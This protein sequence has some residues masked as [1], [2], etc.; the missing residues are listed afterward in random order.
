MK[1]KG[2]T[3][4][5]EPVFDASKTWYL[6]PLSPDDDFF[7]PLYEGKIIEDKRFHL[8]FDD[9]ETR[10]SHIWIADT[11]NICRELSA[12]LIFPVKVC[13]DACIEIEKDNNLFWIVSKVELLKPINYWELLPQSCNEFTGN[14]V[15]HNQKYIPNGLV[16]P[17]ILKGGLMFLNCI[18]PDE[19]EL[20]DEIQEYMT[21]SNSNI[22][23]S[24][25]DKFPSKIDTLTI[26]STLFD[27]AIELPPNL[28]FDEKQVNIFILDNCILPDHFEFPVADSYDF[29]FRDQPI[30][31]RL[32]LP[33]DY[34]G[35]IVF[36]NSILPAWLKLPKKINGEL[37]FYKSKITAALK[38]PENL[39]GKL[40]F[41]K[42]KIPEGF[43]FPE[44]ISGDLL[45]YDCSLPTNI[46][47]PKT[48]E[49]YFVI[50]GGSIPY[51]WKTTLPK[52]VG[53]LIL[54]NLTVSSGTVLPEKINGQ[55]FFDELIAFEEGVIMPSS[56]QSIYANFTDFPSD[57]KLIQSDL[58]KVSFENCILPV[59]F[60][61]P[62][63]RSIELSMGSTKI[64]NDLHLPENFVG[65]LSFCASKIAPR[66][67]LPK[68]F[69]GY[70]DF[71]NLKFPAKLELPVTF[72][73]L[74][75]F[76]LT[77]LP[78]GLKLPDNFT[79][80]LSFSE[81]IMPPNLKFP[82]EF[83]G[84]LEFSEVS[85]PEGFEMPDKL[86]GTLK[87]VDSKINGRLQLH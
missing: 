5:A 17:T 20:P 21:I 37:S 40:E 79:G 45:F 83:H 1:K 63:A 13:N 78:K 16:F 14:I 27:S 57:F 84:K 47:L 73:G 55:L 54:C 9:D 28:K 12:P 48:I 39:T 10:L 11:I 22:P 72:S 49:G 60:S 66:V 44:S 46:S 33:E 51:S 32:K 77:T 34:T 80:E 38:L 59:S 42:T 70:M 18:L 58:E 65:T 31:A 74:L 71:Y 87:I 7:G 30:P 53:N 36:S 4:I 43:A 3:D 50:S 6:L 15:L 19:I 69:E 81:L 56:Y 26:I 62:K 41:R 35:R 86:V 68:Q 8:I 61:I 67:K 25:K 64:N 29:F 2:Y 76:G 23:K 82:K 52:E 85:V 24:W 75:R